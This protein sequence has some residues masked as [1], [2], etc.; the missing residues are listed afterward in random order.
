MSDHSPM[1]THIYH[2]PIE[3]TKSTASSAFRIMTNKQGNQFIGRYKKSKS[4]QHQNDLI[5]LVKQEAIKRG[6]KPFAID[7]PLAVTIWFKFKSVSAPAR[8]RREGCWRVSKPDLDNSSK[9][10]LDAF[11][12]SGLLADDRQ[13]SKL[14]LL[15]CNLPEGREPSMLVMIEP[16]PLWLPDNVP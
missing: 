1:T 11:V 16:M 7:E 14:S 10:V 15:K 8:L 2:L 3:P 9:V 6:F 12:Q 4:K 5:H 13:V